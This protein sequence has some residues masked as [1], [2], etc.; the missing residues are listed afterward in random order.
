M[1][2]SFRLAIAG[3]WLGLLGMPRGVAS[4]TPE[5]IAFFETKIRPVLAQHCYE[6]HSAEALRTGKLKASLLVDSREGMAKGGE[7]GAAVVP[8]KR[9]DSILLAALK[10]DGFEMPPAG[11]LPAEVI[12]DFETWIDMGAPDP[13]DEPLATIDE[14]TIDVAEGRT[15][16][17]YRRLAPVSAPEVVDAAWP[18]NDIDRFILARLEQAG[19]AP[20]A[21]ASKA[22]L[23][24]RAFFDLTG[25]P[26]APEELR[27]F[28]DD[29]SPDAYEKLVDRLLSSPRFGERWARHWL[30]TV[31]YGESGGYEFD[32]DRPHAHH[33]RDWVIKALNADLPYDEFLRMQVAGDLIRPGDYDATAATGFLV[34]GPYPGQVTAKTAEPIRY[35]QLDDMVASLGSSVLGM[36]IGCARCHD[37]KYDPI[38]HRDY[39]AMIACLGQAV[40]TDHAIDREPEKTK[41]RQE[42]WEAERRP[43]ADSFERFLSAEVP[44]RI[45]RWLATEAPAG[46]AP[47]W[48]TLAPESLQAAKA[49]LTAEADDTIVAS[50]KLE[51]NDTYT[52]TF[53]THQRGIQALRLDALATSLAP[54]GGPGTGPDGAFRLSTVVVTATP[55]V[56]APDRNTFNPQL[57]AV[58]ATSEARGSEFDKALDASHLTGWSVDGASGKDQ[59]AVFAFDKPLGFEGGTHLTVVLRFEEGHHGLARLRLAMTTGMPGNALAAGGAPQAAREIGEILEAARAAG[60]DLSDPAVVRD[61]ARWLGRFD[62]R[63]K[64]ELEALAAIEAKKPRPDLVMVYGATNGPWVI[65][66]NAQA[67]KSGSQEVFVLA[68]GEVG[69]KK[70]KATPGFVLA[71]LPA[72][73]AEPRLLSDPTAK[74]LPDSRLGLAAFLTDVAHG[75]GPLAARVI[76]NRIW[77]HHFGRGIAAT[78][79]DLGTQ[80]DPASHP[81]LLEWLANRLVDERWSLKSIHRLIVTSAA[82]RQ[83][84]AV[85]AAGREQDPDN[86]LLWHRRPTRLEGES[87]RDALLAAAGT[88][89]PAMHG[90]TGL[91]VNVP[92]RSIYLTVKRS[93]PIGFLQ[94]FDQPEPVQPVGARG[95]A[96]VP[97]QALTMMNSPFVR[98]AAD[99]LAQRARTALAIPPAEASGAAAIDF[100]FLAALSRQPSDTEREKFATLLAARERAAG[101]DAAGRRTALADVCHLIFC[102]NE[103]VYVD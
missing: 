9:H 66:G 73:D 37:H 64:R 89:D 101:A 12:N 70:G 39:Y 83:S 71:T 44:G 68:R 11:K 69:R 18:R 23:A 84:G 20:A 86:R 51:A 15:H 59:A 74:P 93:E 99:N 96:T 40:Q 72:D 43:V 97:T 35:D 50:G 63:V 2:R 8:G 29:A 88:L 98:S 53:R 31:R 48:L 49:T 60:R 82:Y 7:S 10:Y 14:R 87:I 42:A 67:V 80:G 26:P 77:H 45:A 41:Q 78:P 16:W 85:T 52:L 56:P 79:N 90:R 22:T 36:T 17:S 76:V 24:R 46:Q 1:H 54:G 94:V 33:Y 57:A 102:L 19:I 103:F 92:R 61:A 4:P 34:A 100:C 38:G 32:G 3:L 91:D 25:L 27:A 58:I 28:L 62:G 65:T 13:R 30:D 55:L 47:A 75:A 6:C 95:V 5:Q 81:E 21:E